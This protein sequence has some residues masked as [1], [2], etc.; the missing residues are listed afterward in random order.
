MPKNTLSDETLK[1]LEEAAS[2]LNKLNLGNKSSKGKIL[3]TSDD[4]R[5]DYPNA[6]KTVYL[7]LKNV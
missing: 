4:V 7:K 5:S 6:S 1:L 2:D 3:D